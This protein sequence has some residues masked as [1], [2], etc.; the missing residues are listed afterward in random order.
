[1]DLYFDT[2]PD[3]NSYEYSGYGTK[4]NP[5]TQED[6]IKKFDKVSFGI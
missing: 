6:L 4:D 5:F 2:H 1:M 3:L